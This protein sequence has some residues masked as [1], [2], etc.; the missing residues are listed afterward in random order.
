MLLPDGHLTLIRHPSRLIHSTRLLA[1]TASD[2]ARDVLRVVADGGDDG[3]YGSLLLEGCEGVC[4]LGWDRLD[5][6]A[7]EKEADWVEADFV[8]SG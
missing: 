2:N 1:P 3:G 7:V 5:C 4:G 6:R 8:C